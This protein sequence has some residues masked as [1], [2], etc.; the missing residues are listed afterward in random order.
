MRLRDTGEGKKGDT[1]ILRFYPLSLCFSGD[2]SLRWGVKKG[3]K[4]NIKVKLV[5]LCHMEVKEASPASL[6]GHATQP[7]PLSCCEFW[8]RLCSIFVSSESHDFVTQRQN[9]GPDVRSPKQ[10]A[11]SVYYVTELK[12]FPRK[13]LFHSFLDGLSFI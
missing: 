1:E 10:D 13:S 12:S 9:I 6:S 8:R 4:A 7:F 11:A 3:A 5:K 2:I